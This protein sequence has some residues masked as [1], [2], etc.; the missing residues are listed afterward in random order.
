MTT[1]KQMEYHCFD[2]LTVLLGLSQKRLTA[3]IAFMKTAIAL[4]SPILVANLEF[5]LCPTT[6]EMYRMT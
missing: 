2:K 3:K 4:R 6:K 5:V 1:Q